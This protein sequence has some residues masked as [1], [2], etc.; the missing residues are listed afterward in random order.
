[1]DNLAYHFAITS[2]FKR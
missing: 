1:M 2:R